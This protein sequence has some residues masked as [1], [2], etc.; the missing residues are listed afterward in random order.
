MVGVAVDTLMHAGIVH[1]YVLAGDAATCLPLAFVLP[2]V[3]P[4]VIDNR[5]VI[6]ADPADQCSVDALI[7]NDPERGKI[8]SFATGGELES[9]RFVDHRQFFREFHDLIGAELATVP[10][11][12]TIEISPYRTVLVDIDETEHEFLGIRVKTVPD[13]FDL[14]DQDIDIDPV[15][16]DEWIESPDDLLLSYHLGYSLERRDSL[17]QWRDTGLKLWFVVVEGVLEIIPDTQFVDLVQPGLQGSRVLGPED[18]ELQVLEVHDLGPAVHGID[19]DHVPCLQPLEE[20]VRIERR[21][22][23]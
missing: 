8:D 17:I 12:G 7:V 19:P 15:G 16:E 6:G 23:G 2:G 4:D 14:I 5:P 18:D 10:Q 3:P 1:P 9:P 11:A 22:V 21:D 20:P 13:S